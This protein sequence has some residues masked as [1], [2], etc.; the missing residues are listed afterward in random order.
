MDL[1]AQN[2][3]ALPRPPLGSVCGSNGRQRCGSD[4]RHSLAG[5]A[6]RCFQTL[7]TTRCTHRQNTA[8]LE[9]TLQK[10]WMTPK[11][12]GDA[13]RTCSRFVV[14]TD[15]QLLTPMQSLVEVHAYAL[16]DLRSSLRFLKELKHQRLCIST[17]SRNC[18]F[19]RIRSSWY[20][21]SSITRPSSKT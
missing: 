21:P 13:Q 17:I 3:A 2:N 1:R 6:P 12:S 11:F 19:S 14:D 4:M 15:S 7:G 8:A 9:A 5:S 20:E 18:P 10:Q 16:L